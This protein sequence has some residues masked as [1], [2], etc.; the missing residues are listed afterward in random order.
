MF[1]LPPLNP[2]STACCLCCAPLNTN[3]LISWKQKADQSTADDA[4]EQ[5]QAKISDMGLGKLLDLTTSGGNLR[6]IHVD[7]S[8]LNRM[9]KAWEAGNKAAGPG[10]PN[11]FDLL[12]SRSSSVITP[13]TIG[14]QAPEILQPLVNASSSSSGQQ[15]R[16][17]GGALSL[18]GE[19]MKVVMSPGDEYWYT[20]WHYFQRLL[21]EEGTAVDSE[22]HKVTALQQGEESKQLEETKTNVEAA[23]AAVTPSSAIASHDSSSSSTL[24][25]DGSKPSG[26]RPRHSR[27]VDVWSLGCVM[28]SVL[29]PDEH[30]YGDWI[31]REANVLQG[32]RDLSKLQHLPDAEHLIRSMTSGEIDQLLFPVASSS[33]LVTLLLLSFPSQTQIQAQ[34]CQ[35]VGASILLD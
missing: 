10:R 15:R 17:S 34:H 18:Q 26:S 21:K 13:G 30:P 33:S 19:G 4:W 12:H 6:D 22:G 8:S 31:T 28:Y 35:S 5:W 23:T 29:V 7:P 11:P 1:C 9:K 16:G 32:K 25:S 2:F 14:W 3:I 24:Q 27:A 20:G